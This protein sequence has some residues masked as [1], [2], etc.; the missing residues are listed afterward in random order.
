MSTQNSKT[1]ELLDFEDITHILTVGLVKCDSVTLDFF[2]AVNLLT[3][4]S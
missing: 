2:T 3:N 1:E 4:Y